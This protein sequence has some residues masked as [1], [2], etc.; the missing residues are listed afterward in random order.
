MQ[1]QSN[2]LSLLLMLGVSLLGTHAFAQ[3]EMTLK[4]D[5]EKLSYAL[6]LDLGNQMRQM[7]VDVN[8]AIFARGMTDGLSGDKALMTQDEIRLQIT[9]LQAEIMRRHVEAKKQEADAHATASESGPKDSGATETT[10]PEPTARR[11]PIARPSPARD[12][13]P[14]GL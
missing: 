3:D 14:L 11:G 7:S 12:G 10:P 6:G 1:R 9:K 2:P 5:Q 4:D 8:P 13:V